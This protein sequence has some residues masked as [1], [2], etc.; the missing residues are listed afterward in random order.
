VSK[1][2]QRAFDRTSRGCD[3]LDGVPDPDTVII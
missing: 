1:S 2:S 3:G